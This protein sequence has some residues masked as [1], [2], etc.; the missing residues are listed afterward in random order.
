MFFKVSSDD[1]N[2]KRIFLAGTN[3][4]LDGDAVLAVID[5]RQLKSGLAP[6]YTIPAG[7]EDKKDKL[8][9]YIPKH[10]RPAHQAYYMRVKRNEFCRNMGVKWLY[11]FEIHTGKNEI[12]VQVFC[13]R[14]LECALYY[15]FDPGFNLRYV[16][17][18]SEL[19]RR[20]TKMLNQG[21]LNTS[22]EDFLLQ[23]KNDVSFWDGKGWAKKP[24]PLQISIGDVP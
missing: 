10:P 4:L 20:Y 8:R 24:K 18:G 1:E 23:R 22:L 5:S 21:L 19:E 7:L 6:P 15:S 17:A 11:I 2:Q 3:N 14:G 13:D 16:I 12:M 9:I